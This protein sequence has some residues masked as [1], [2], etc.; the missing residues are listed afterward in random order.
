MRKFQ[1]ELHIRRIAAA[2]PATTV[3][4]DDFASPLDL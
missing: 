2:L 1:K 4:G 3:P